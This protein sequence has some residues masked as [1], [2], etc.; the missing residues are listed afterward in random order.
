MHIRMATIHDLDAIH[1]IGL[2]CPELQTNPTQPF[3]EL[4]EL[5]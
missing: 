4:E 5:H 2:G 3:M 1:A